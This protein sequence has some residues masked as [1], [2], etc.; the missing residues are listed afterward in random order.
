MQGLGIEES[1]IPVSDEV[2]GACELLG[3]DP[4]HRACESTLLLAVSPEQAAKAL[5]ALRTTVEGKHAVEIG[6]VRVKTSAPVTILR[7]GRELPLD[8]PTG[9][10]LPQIC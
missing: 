4:I 3:L 2:R 10:P 9:P 8:E 7:A 1:S 6:V 5:A